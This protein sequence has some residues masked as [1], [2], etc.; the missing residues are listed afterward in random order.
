VK[1][2]LDT[3]AVTEIMRGTLVT[4]DLDHMRRVPGLR[5]ESWLGDP[6]EG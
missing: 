4:A 6:G 2:V 3:N 1:Y 5:V